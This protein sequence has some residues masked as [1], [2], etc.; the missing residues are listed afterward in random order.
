MVKVLLAIFLTL[1]M[2]HFFKIKYHLVNPMISH[3]IDIDIDLYNSHAFLFDN[4]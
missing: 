3:Y 2:F 1:K 4:I